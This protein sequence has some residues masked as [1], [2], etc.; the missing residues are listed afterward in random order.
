MRVEAVTDRTTVFLARVT[1]ITLFVCLTLQAD[2]LAQG[3]P[4]EEA[5]QRM[6]VAEGFKVELVASEPLVRQPVAIDIDD[7]GRLWVLQYLQYPNPAGLKRVKVD[8]FS[9]TTYDRIPEPPPAGPKGADRLT[10]LED[11]NGDGQFDRARDFIS[12][13]NIASGFAFGHGGVFV[14]QTPYLLF[15][16][17][18]N[19][20]DIPDG[21]PEV[22]LKGF[23]ME[24]TSSV[25][26][27]LVWGPDG[28]LYG[29]QGTNITAH[30]RG[31]EFEQG[32]WRY[33]PVSRKFELFMEGGGNMWG[34][35]FDQYG[36]LLAGT[37][38]GGYL[39]IHCVQGA[40]YA[41]SFA[42][43]GELHNP[44]ALGYFQHVPHKNFQGGHVTVGGF[45][46]Q[47]DQ[48]PSL[49]R[50]KYIAV[51]TLAHAVRWHHTQPDQSTF[52]SENGGVL[53][54]AN[55]TWFAP[56]DATQGPDGAVY[57]ADWHD[58]R[59]AHPD[60]DATWDRSNG[61][62]FRISSRSAKPVRHVDPHSLSSSQLVD[63][64]SSSN[65]WQVRR[66]RRM[67]SERRDA[68]AI[69]TLR[70]LSQNSDDQKLALQAL[71][72]LNAMGA[73]DQVQ[74]GSLLTHQDPHIRAWT[75]R[76]I[77]DTKQV[78]DENW[79]KLLSIAKTDT[80]PTVIS[81]L[82]SSAKRLPATQC[83]ALVRQIL[84]R[85]EF[86]NDPH[87]PLLLWW[88]LER[89]AVS[90]TDEVLQVFSRPDD[91]QNP[92]LREVILGRLMR[93]YAGEGS[94]ASLAACARLL[95]TAP[96]EGER[97]RM[98]TELDAG[99]KMLGRERLPGLPLG[100]KYGNIAAISRV[101]QSNQVTRLKT[102]PPELA[103][104]LAT[105]WNDNTTDPLLIR[106]AMR[107]GS[108]AAYDRALNLATDKT[109]TEKT[110]LDMLAILQELGESQECRD[111]VLKLVDGSETPSIQRAALNLLSRF[112][113]E[114]ITER[115]LAQYEKMDATLRSHTRDVLLGRADS[116]LVFLKVIDDGTYPLTEV[117]ADQ[118]RRVALHN[119]PRLNE[120]VRK[121]WGN[122]RA[123]TPEEKLAE[124][125]RISNDLR[126]GSGN[127]AQG[128]LLFEKQCATCHK[129]NDDGK[130]IGPDLTKANRQDQSFLLVSIVDPNT[131]IRKEY[132]N[133][134]LVTIN[135]RVLTGLLVE[136]SPASVTLL[137]AKNERTTV[138]RADIEELKAS[139]VSLMPEDLLKKLT[140][141]QVRDL[142]QYL[143]TKK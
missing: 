67:L 140:P 88:A 136:E 127:L 61:R 36:N 47:S 80:S 71:W 119:D 29:T 84:D 21:D 8:R 108:K 94:N 44:F 117:S 103:D 130:E 14:L 73:F 87:I 13:L 120:L 24:D 95:A 23:G 45:L 58:Q 68:Q 93:R 102:L 7:R 34:L 17:D 75:I 38:Y 137:N 128:K 28:W 143:Q 122:I 52:R 131:Q 129:L 85:S 50:N 90:H 33:H 35:D 70:T 79:Q 78:S 139:P 63:L 86:R 48:F 99:L 83:I 39:M 112:S 51:D 69:D 18:R 65:E 82:A 4:P 26:N 37:N 49:Y 56:S 19:R 89:N 135:G 42:K 123:G 27:S 100:P 64:L 115:L 5:V 110:R 134:I 133:Y 109:R 125:R 132:L 92:F 31:I 10:I 2:C 76:L 11:T 105:I 25:A 30:I 22:L 12:D 77:G 40:Y 6:T 53:L 113:D 20:D 81:Q 16:P 98:L 91:W 106:V 46:Y 3:F 60:P 104:Q 15:Y 9:R 55:D 124:I 142:F 43:H 96:E 62:V 97:R 126:A 41:K 118:L 141:Q 114:R 101:E 66:A 116:A 57:I 72:T 1:V 107:L 54:Q 59:T 74:E 121:H 138:S 111:R 32:I